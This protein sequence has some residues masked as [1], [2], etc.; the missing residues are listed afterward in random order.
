MSDEFIFPFEKLE[1]WHLAVGLSDTVF[2]LFETFPENKYFR[3][4][5]Q[6]ESAVSS[7]AQNIAEGVEHSSSATLL[8]YSVP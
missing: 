5:G 2:R 7:I 6:M 1:V 3:L 4:M 8:I